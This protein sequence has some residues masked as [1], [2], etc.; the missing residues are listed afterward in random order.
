MPDIHFPRVK[1]IKMSFQKNERNDCSSFMLYH[2][3]WYCNYD[4]PIS[5]TCHARSQYGNKQYISSRKVSFKQSAIFRL[6]EITLDRYSNI[7]SSEGPPIL[8]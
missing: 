1:I 5:R 4:W 2:M 3:L 8:P 7:V 6:F